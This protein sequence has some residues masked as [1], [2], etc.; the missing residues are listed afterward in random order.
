MGP[1]VGGKS[2]GSKG[3]PVFSKSRSKAPAWAIVVQI[4]DLMADENYLKG[5]PFVVAGV[6]LAGIRTLLAY[7]CSKKPIW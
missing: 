5:D 3:P 2:Q 6:E 4:V 1:P 7:P